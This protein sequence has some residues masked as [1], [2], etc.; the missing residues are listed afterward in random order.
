MQE[1]DISG[2]D[3]GD[4]RVGDLVHQLLNLA[5]AL[6][7]DTPETSLP[8]D[9]INHSEARSGPASGVGLP[10]PVA[11]YSDARCVV[12]AQD[13]EALLR[14]AQGISVQVAGDLA[15]RVAA[16]RFAETGAK[17][18]VSLLVQSLR[19][20]AREASKRIHVAAQVLP[21]VDGMTGQAA[22]AAHPGVGQTFFEG[23][24]SQEQAGMVLGFVADAD[25]LAHDGRITQEVC[26]AVEQDLLDAARDHDPDFVRQLGNRIM[27][28]IDPDGNKPSA[29]DLRAKQGLF[30][31]RARRGLVTIYGA[32]T[33]EQY[34][35]IMAAIA[36]DTNPNK[37]KDIN[38]INNDGCEGGDSSAGAD[39]RAGDDAGEDGQESLLDHLEDL[40][41]FFNTTAPENNTDGDDNGNGRDDSGNEDSGDER[42]DERGNGRGDGADDGR[43]QQSGNGI[44]NGNGDGDGD[45]IPEGDDD[46]H[47]PGSDEGGRFAD[48]VASPH[49]SRSPGA[50][51]AA[52]PGPQPLG[53][54]QLPD[55]LQPPQPAAW[56][57]PPEP[58]HPPDPPVRP[59][60]GPDDALESSRGIPGWSE[61]WYAGADAGWGRRLEDWEIPPRP[62]EAPENAVPPVY[63]GDDWF[64]FG[65]QP[66][67]T[68]LWTPSTTGDFNIWEETPPPPPPPP[69]PWMRGPS[70]TATTNAPAAVPTA[71]GGANG[72]APPNN[73]ASADHGPAPD[74]GPAR[75]EG[76][77]PGWD[78][79]RLGEP[80]HD[81]AAEEASM[82]WPRLIDGA[83]VPAPG[84]EQDMPGLDSTDPDSTDPATRDTRTHGQKVLDGLI[85]CVK[86]AARTGTLPMN[87]GLRTQLIISCSEEDLHR[88]DGCGTAYTTHSGPMP[89]GLFAD[90]LCDAETTRFVYGDGQNIINAGR[91]QRLF[92]LAQRKLLYARDLGCSFPDCRDPATRCEGHH[93]QPW[94]LGGKTDLNNA[95]LL[96][97]RHHTLLHQSDWS[98]KLID[99]TPWYTPPYVM[100]RSQKPRRNNYHHGLSKNNR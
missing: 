96:C 92:T 86:L 97:S 36:S 27:S 28:V 16:G 6:N 34:E 68:G 13:V 21:V 49:G 75:D 91:T 99:G 39:D 23:A 66:T 45:V 88:T 17:G 46:D 47:I 29:S 64:W 52:Q 85:A 65:P 2:S 4:V 82:P 87:G 11:D 70:R 94:Q 60:S 44:G 56:P 9:S 98:V 20:S 89:L 59:E 76:F 51:G 100:D 24:I 42:G 77:G 61:T 54:P 63:E 84:S 48:P 26:A 35:Q 73:G 22:P 5:A 12:V 72:T 90:S 67:T 19:L 80:R 83:W 30:F 31:R 25:R 33:I 74:D 62:P 71:A 55:R 81:D 50:W 53:Q 3:S 14:V 7:P 41:T 58:P 10:L 1:P 37:H 93:I 43:Y 78:G 79:G 18:A 95:V 15:Q 32:C 57:E 8:S 40:A 38:S 69:S